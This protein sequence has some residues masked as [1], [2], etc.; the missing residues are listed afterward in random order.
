LRLA[1]LQN[2]NWSI[3][4]IAYTS[5]FGNVVLDSKGYPHL[6][7]QIDYPEFTGK[8]NSTLVYASWTGTSWNTQTVN[9]DRRAVGPCYLALD[10]NGNPNISFRAFSPSYYRSAYIVYA[11]ANTV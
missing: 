1:T 9:T 3:Q 7:Y 6:I 5:G 4:T 2:S 11:T 8:D 10:S